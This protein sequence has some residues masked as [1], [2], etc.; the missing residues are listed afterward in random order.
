MEKMIH[1]NT[2]EPTPLETAVAKQIL[3]E[4]TERDM[5]QE[6]LADALGTTPATLNR[7]LRGKRSMPM[8]TFFRVASI[9]GLEP[10][11]LL[12]RAAA[13]LSN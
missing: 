2:T 1:M 4:L 13:R 9:L 6:Q 11:T 10:D 12:S 5:T 7:Y 3:V 8:P